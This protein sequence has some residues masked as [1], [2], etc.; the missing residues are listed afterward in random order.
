[1][2]PF[3]VNIVPGRRLVALRLQANGKTIYDFRTDVSNPPPSSGSTYSP[4]VVMQDFAAVCG[5]TYTVNI[6]GQD[7]G[8]PSFLNMGQFEEVVCPSE[9]P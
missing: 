8:D 3:T 9:V 4:S 1:V 7:S 5:E 6:L 2:D